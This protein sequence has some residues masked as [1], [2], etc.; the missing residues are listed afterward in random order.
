MKKIARLLSLALALIMVLSL[1]ACGTP[2]AEKDLEAVKEAGVIKIGMECNYAPFNWTAS[3]ENE[4]TLPVTSGGFAGGYDVRIA[5]MI[6]EALDVDVQ[7]VKLE[8]DGLIPALNSGEIDCII[9]GMSPTA[10]RDEEIDF[11]EN[12]YT[13]DLCIVIK[14][15]S[16]YAAAASLAD[17]SGAKIT[18][19]LNTYHYNA[20]DQIDGVQKQTALADFPTMIVALQSGEIDGYVSEIPGA[21]SAAA[22]NDDLTYIEFEDGKGFNCDPDD[23][24]IAV[25]V[26][27]GSSLTEEINKA[28]ADISED[29]RLD[30]MNWAVANQPGEE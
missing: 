10:E 29:T 15:D 13:S 4:Y 22:A 11:S 9:A 25:G 7:V 18:G 20:I 2:S 24:S 14:K 8:W 6:G 3:E 28:L 27:S 26:R 12:Y 1:A 16:A 30:I 23:T 21:V 5:A 19:Q 17:F